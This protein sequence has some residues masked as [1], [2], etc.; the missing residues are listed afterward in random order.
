M[1]T[2][3]FE[4][5]EC[6]E[7]GIIFQVTEEFAENRELDGEPF[8][9]PNGHEQCYVDGDADKF[10]ELEAKNLELEARNVELQVQARQ[11]KCKLLGKASFIDR[12]KSWWRARTTNELG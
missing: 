6:C 8:Y 12:L 9:C 3:N 1:I 2:V 11:L 5:E 7:C 4:T 10:A